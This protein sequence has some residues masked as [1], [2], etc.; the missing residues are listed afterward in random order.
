MRIDKFSD[1]CSFFDDRPGPLSR[2]CAVILDSAQKK[3]ILLA[4]ADDECLKKFLL[5]AEVQ[6][7]ELAKLGP[8]SSSLELHHRRHS[9]RVAK[10]PH[11]KR[12]ALEDREGN[13]NDD[14]NNDDLEIFF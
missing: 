13:N 8:S 5:S 14:D 9:E 2:I 12:M 11:K 1:F 3:G 4:R 6:E 7:R 10:K